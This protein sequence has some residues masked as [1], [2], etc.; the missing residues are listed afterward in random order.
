MS[1]RVKGAQKH[2]QL[3]QDAMGKILEAQQD[4]CMPYRA[5]LMFFEVN[6]LYGD[7][8]DAFLELRPGWNFP[9][10]FVTACGSDSHFDWWLHNKR[11][12]LK[13]KHLAGKLQIAGFSV[14]PEEVA[15][16]VMEK[17]SSPP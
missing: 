3:G 1:W 5:F 14:L 2:A 15:K 10:F 6:M 4:T 11:E 16:D 13:S 8:F 7:M 12:L 17:S 9:T